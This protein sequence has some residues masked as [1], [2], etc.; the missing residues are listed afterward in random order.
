MVWHFRYSSLT[1]VAAVG[2]GAM[3]GAPPAPPRQGCRCCCCR[4]CRPAWREA[5]DDTVLHSLGEMCGGI[6]TEPIGTRPRPPSWDG[7]RAPALPPAPRGDSALSRCALCKGGPERGGA[8]PGGVGLTSVPCS[9]E[10]GWGGGPGQGLD[11]GLRPPRCLKL[12]GSETPLL[13]DQCLLVPAVSGKGLPGLGAGLG[14]P[15]LLLPQFGPGRP[16]PRVARVARVAAAQGGGRPSA[17]GGARSSMTR[18]RCACSSS[19]ARC[20]GW[21]TAAGCSARCSSPSAAMPMLCSR[22]CPR[23]R[24]AARGAP[25]FEFAADRP[26]SLLARPPLSTTALD[27]PRSPRS[28]CAK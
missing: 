16:G 18:R 8:G 7:V 2:L 14:F 23:A 26:P 12:A 11:S 24:C 6:G 17:V 9:L 20:A 1:T 21:P 4:S 25:Q 10:T 5:E 13:S 22:A 28:S 3:L 15:L 19:P 27:L